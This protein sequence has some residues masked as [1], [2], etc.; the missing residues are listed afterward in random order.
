[1]DCRRFEGTKLRVTV[2]GSA[3]AAWLLAARTKQPAMVRGG[4]QQAGDGYISFRRGALP[5]IL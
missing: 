5:T 3:A 2:L 4:I 1:L